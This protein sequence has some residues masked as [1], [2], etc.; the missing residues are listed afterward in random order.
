MIH[1]YAHY[2]ARAARRWPDRIALIDGGRRRTYSELDERATRLARALC[3]LGLVPGERV[4]VV[5]ENRIE[6]AETVIAIAR[7]GGVLVPLLGA[8][9]EA[10]HAFMVRDAEA[11]LAK[12]PLD[13]PAIRLGLLAHGQH[14][15]LL[16]CEPERERPSEMLD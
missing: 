15:R 7:A 14:P 6:Y 10:E 12:L 9:T 13:A 16:R 3:G 1:P 11:R 5:Q 8:L 4:A 2:P